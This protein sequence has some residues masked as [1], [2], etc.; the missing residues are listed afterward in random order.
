VE[1]FVEAFK[2]DLPDWRLSH[3]HR[4]GEHKNYRTKKTGKTWLFSL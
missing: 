4:S 1:Q 3:E 2:P